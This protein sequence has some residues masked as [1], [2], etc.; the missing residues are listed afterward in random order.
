[1]RILLSIRDINQVFLNEV[2][3]NFLLNKQILKYR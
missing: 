3:E 1:M 2:D